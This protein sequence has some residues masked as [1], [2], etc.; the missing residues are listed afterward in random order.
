MKDIGIETVETI[1][2]CKAHR[3]GKSIITDIG[4]IAISELGNKVQ[5]DYLTYDCFGDLETL[6]VIEYK[7]MLDMYMNEVLLFENILMLQPEDMLVKVIRELDD[8]IA[9]VINPEK[10]V[11]VTFHNGRKIPYSFVGKGIN[12]IKYTMINAIN[13]VIKY[14]NTEKRKIKNIVYLA[15]FVT[16]LRVGAVLNIWTNGIWTISIDISNV[17]NYRYWISC[18][19]KNGNYHN[20]LAY[21]NNGDVV[22]DYKIVEVAKKALISIDKSIKERIQEIT[23]LNIYYNKLLREQLRKE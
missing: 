12:E 3:A 21:V 20:S 13:T 6:E 7:S 16:K 1:F 4:E 18:E 10:I 5:V 15:E 11:E 8:D 14:L 9:T 19:Y 2:K 22:A 17:G 23:K